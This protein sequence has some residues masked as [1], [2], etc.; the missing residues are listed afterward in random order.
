MNSNTALL[1]SCRCGWIALADSHPEAHDLYLQHIFEATTEGHAVN[2]EMAVSM[3]SDEFNFTKLQDKINDLNRV[4]RR[5]AVENEIYAYGDRI[6]LGTL[7]RKLTRGGINLAGIIIVM[8]LLA[9][10]VWRIL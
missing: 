1:Q 7:E 6:A 9:W 5:R 10:E 8:G 4:E 2:R 3:P